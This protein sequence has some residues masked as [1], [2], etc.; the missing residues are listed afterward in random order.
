[1]GETARRIEGLRDIAGCGQKDAAG[2]M[3][4]WNNFCT[5]AAPG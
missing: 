2:A 5:C 3:D 1:M 4:V